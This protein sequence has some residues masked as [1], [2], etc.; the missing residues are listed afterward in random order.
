MAMIEL[1]AR[2]PLIGGVAI[3]ARRHGPAERLADAVDLITARNRRHLARLVQD[4]EPIVRWRAD[5]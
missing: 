2:L 3:V 1:A 5:P 4:V